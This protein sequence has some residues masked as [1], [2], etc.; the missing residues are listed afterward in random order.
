MSNWLQRDTP[1]AP[2]NTGPIRGLLAKYEAVYATVAEQRR[3]IDKQLGTDDSPPR[4]AALTNLQDEANATIAQLRA[5]IADAFK[6]A[7]GQA[8]ANRQKAVR[9]F[10]ASTDGA[11]YLAALGVFA[12]LAQ[13]L[14]G[15]GIAARLDAALDAGLIGQARAW[16]DVAELH[17]SEKGT[18]ALY[19]AIDRA[20]AGALTPA[21][22]LAQKEADYL[23]NAE[24]RYQL[25]AT[26][27]GDSRLRYALD[28]NDSHAAGNFG[29]GV[30]MD[31]G[32]PGDGGE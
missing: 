6:A 9:D 27:Q 17:R 30:I 10:A 24:R 16:Q 8:N 12:Q 25:F 13:S 14:D 18:G 23:A 29:P 1:A 3:A 5:Q 19:M 31:G 28:G 7:H 11:Q 26:A 22:L 4:R 20:K 21:E 2:I 32:T 15:K